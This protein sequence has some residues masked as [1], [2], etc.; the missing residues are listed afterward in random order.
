MLKQ[1]DRPALEQLLDKLAVEYRLKVPKQLADGTRQLASYGDGVISLSGAVLH[2]KPTTYFF[3]QIERLLTIDAS[4]TVSVPV[5]AE[6]PLALFGLNRADLAGV[7]FLDRFFLTAPVDDAYLR[8]R[9]GALLIGLTGAAGPDNSFLPLS[10]G[11]CDI[12]MI[13]IRGSWMALGHSNVGKR[14]LLD[15]PDGDPE[16]MVALRKF[17]ESNSGHQDILQKA[18]QLLTDDKVPDQFWVEIADRCILCSG[19]NLACPTCNCFGVQDRTSEKGTERSRVWDS[20][21]L[22]AFMREASGHNPLGTEALRTRRRIHHKLVADVERW[23]ELGC[24]ACGRCDR[25]CPT[26]IGMMAVAEELVKRY[27]EIG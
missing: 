22:D 13:A 7:T 12:E 15:F 20:C 2:R 19:C 25:A 11:D 23:G 3:P 18:S 9:S 8:N 26:G 4:G 1:L 27:G 5:Q 17:S 14:L 10:V 21:Q 24:V 16:R 6:K